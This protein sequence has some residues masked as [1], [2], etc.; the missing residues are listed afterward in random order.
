MASIQFGNRSLTV[1]PDRI[2]ARPSNSATEVLLSL[3]TESPRVHP[4]QQPKSNC[5]SRPHL[6]ASIQFG[7]RSLT[8]SPDRISA[9][10]FNSATK[11]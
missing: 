3:Q 1:S 10:P 2:S 5:L 8:V 9:R 4:I 6:R 7:N 11:V